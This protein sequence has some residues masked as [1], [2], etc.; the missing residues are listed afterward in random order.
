[1]CPVYLSILP[2]STR[3]TD[4]L[5]LSNLTKPYAK[6]L[7]TRRIRQP[8][9]AKTVCKILSTGCLKTYI[10][11]TGLAVDTHLKEH[12]KDISKFKKKTFTKSTRKEST[13]DQHKSAIMD[14][15]KPQNMLLI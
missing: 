6:C 7:C 15:V 2:E 3:N 14:H 1:M 4:L 8:P 13:A 11:E 9:K 12:K 10:E 5:H